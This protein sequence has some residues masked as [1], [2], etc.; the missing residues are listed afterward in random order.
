MSRTDIHFPPKHE[1][2][3]EDV[4]ALGTLVGEIL[5]EQGGLQL[6]ELVE[7]D[8]QAAIRRRNGD[9]QARLELAAS[10]RDR[11]PQL[12]RD[13]VRAF[14][15]WF[16]A[17]NL[18]EKVHR[19]RRRRTYFRQDT[20]RPQPAGVEDAVATLKSRGLSLEEV[21]SLL[22][23]LRIEPVFAAHSME[24]T[25]RTLLRKQQRVAQHLLDRL[26]PMLTPQDS[27]NLWS[28]IR[29]ELT[30]AWQTEELPRER[31]TVGDERE[32]VLFYL[33]E[34]LYRVVPAFYEEIAQ[35]LEKRYGV[36]ADSIELPPILSFGSWVGGDMDGNPDVHAKTIRETLARQQQ[37]ILNSYF[38]D[39]RRLSQRLSQ[40][41]GR[42]AV[43]AELSKR[44]EDYLTLAPSARSV[45]PARHDRMP[46]RVFLA[47]MGERLRL[48]YEGRA[49]GYESARQFRDDVKL[50]ATS[51][52]ANKGANAGLFYIRRLLRRI[53]TFGF[54]LAGLDVRQHAGVLH[55]IIARGNDDPGWL[56]RP[57]AERRRLLAQMLEKDTGP[58]VDLDALGKR[59]LAVFEAF[60]QARHR[61]GPEAVGYFIVS[62]ARGAD[63]VL[64]ALTLARWASVYD[65][66]TGQVALDIA[67][68]FESLGALEQCGDTLRE[69]LAEPVYRRHLEA[70][71]RRQCVLLGYSDSNKEGGLCASRYAIHQAEL[72]LAAMREHDGENY[73]VFHAR[74]GSIARGGGRIDALV[75]SAPAGTLNG[76]LRVREQGETVKQG[77]GLRPIAM[78]SLERAFNALSLATASNRAPAAES[79]AQQL[80]AA[81]LECA[82]TLA[83]ASR[84]AYRRLLYGDAEFHDYFRAVTPIDVIERM[85]V[86]SRPVHREEGRSLEALLP[87]PWVFAW[88]QTRHMLPGWFGAGTGLAAA[89]ERHG[90][91]RMRA[92]YAEWFFLHSLIDDVEA[93]LARADLEIAAAYDVLVPEPLRRFS[94][95]IRAEYELA[96]ERVLWLKGSTNL[97]DGE[98]TLQRS[99]RLRNPY[100]D[101]MNLMQVDLLQRWRAGKRTDRDL[102][103]ALLTSAGGIAQGLQSIA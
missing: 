100:I 96:R 2:L 6:F 24:S 83:D 56:G 101:P 99:I 65:K 85:Q 103:E 90:A 76:I 78:R 49:N 5:L 47:Q 45:T 1:A 73:V 57:A 7:L 68:Q 81:H 25:R 26:D 62:G 59:N 13:L 18:A 98:P 97:L 41:A 46:Y 61:Y 20:G 22:G 52:A 60:A 42:V 69:L 88:T 93:M 48:A 21:L 12:A 55:E 58:R 87:V 51:L 70:H 92:A 77:Y 67:P 95:A 34:I 66:H 36:P 50:I 30:T 86:G 19:I 4:H 37:M 17:V 35:A 33:L 102:F 9:E 91:E 29:I 16:Q 39:C 89:I 38:E 32:Q 28:S 80:S 14:S 54:H 11:P 44:M 72:A 31:L 75:K 84:E 40:S 43:S 94:A 74:G 79:G 3:R 71:G 15:M 8:R 10:V 23:R 64:A 63:D 53:D 82:A 27:R